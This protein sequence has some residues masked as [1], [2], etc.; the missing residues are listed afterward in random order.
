[1]PKFNGFIKANVFM[2][3]GASNSINFILIIYIFS[4][5]YLSMMLICESNKL[6]KIVRNCPKIPTQ[7]GTWG[8]H[9]T[10]YE[11]SNATSN[12]GIKTKYRSLHTL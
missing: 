5:T 3:Y 10:M 6:S 8:K 7:F 9:S 2:N 1:M 12:E 11:Q 4:F